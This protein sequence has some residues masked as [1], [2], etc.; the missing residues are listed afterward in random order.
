MSVTIQIA[1]IL[2]VKVRAWR[3]GT[4]RRTIH[5][6]AA[7][8]EREHFV[9]YGKAVADD[10]DQEDFRTGCLLAG[11]RALRSLSS[12]MQNAG[13]DRVRAADKAKE[14]LV[15]V[16]KGRDEARNAVRSL[17][18]DALIMLYADVGAELDER[19]YGTGDG[20]TS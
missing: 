14:Q 7:G 6:Q 9:G 3:D 17:P 19:G 5:A 10:A 13:W 1:N 15:Q 4:N 2:S 18:L 20:G 8:G 16:A 11:A 12:K